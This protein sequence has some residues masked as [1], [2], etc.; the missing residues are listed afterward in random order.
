MIKNPSTEKIGLIGRVVLELFDESGKLKHKEVLTNLIVN[1]GRSFII[2]RLQAAS[3]AVHDY[4]AIGTGVTA[5]AA[6][7]TTLQT[8]TGRVQG[9]L[10]QPDAYTD[11]C[12]AT[13]GAGVA[14]GSITEVGRLNA[15]TTGVLTGRQT[16]TAIPK[17]A[18]DSLQITYDFTYS[19][20]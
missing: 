5:V 19:A 1:T 12:V 3:P 13:F 4:I 8:E 7:D 18:S 10:T 11:R 9:T 15:A 20:S 14:T 17:G 16:F 6:A 2:D